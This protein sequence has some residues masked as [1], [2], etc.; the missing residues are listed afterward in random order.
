MAESFWWHLLAGFIIGF[1]VSTLWEWLYFRRKRAVIRDRYVAELEATVRTYAAAAAQVDTGAAGDW[2]EPRFE[3]PAIFLETEESLLEKHPSGEKASVA[4]PAA[5]DASSSQAAFS[6]SD[7]AAAPSAS[8]Q[9]DRQETSLRTEESFNRLAKS[10]TSIQSDRQETSAAGFAGKS[11]HPQPATTPFRS[12]AVQQPASSSDWSHA[13]GATQN[14]RD[15]GLSVEVSPEARPSEQP[16]SEAVSQ[17]QKRSD[18]ADVGQPARDHPTTLSSLQE[19]PSLAEAA[20]PGRVESSASSPAQVQPRLTEAE[21]SPSLPSQQASSFAENAQVKR[22]EVAGSPPLQEDSRVQE[23]SRA[24]DP[25]Q[26]DKSSPE[27]PQQAFAAVHLEHAD[28]APPGE[29]LP[30]NAS[31]LRGEGRESAYFV[32]PDARQAPEDHHVLSPSH[33]PTRQHDEDIRSAAPQGR[34]YTAIITSRAEWMLLRIVQAMVQFVRQV[35]S[36]VA[37]E[38]ALR[39]ASHAAKDAA[40]CEDDL[41]RIPGLMPVHAERLRGMGITRYSQVAA[42]T[43]DEL[44]RMTFIPDAT[45]PVDYERWR[46]EAAALAASQ[47]RGGK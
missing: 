3:K 45:K 5:S 13:L 4:S 7:K 33:A 15:R 16:Q 22:D 47:D 10:S 24:S 1:G 38:D 46:K 35:R 40:M 21:P 32:L 27:A 26:A 2:S 6:R 19:R 14:E 37:G 11:S 41:T 12:V 36:A 30:E 28:T 42:L 20:Q 43:V 23:D 25:S 39:P 18:L 8:I 34:V 44:Q 9:S 29:R 31:A 17:Q